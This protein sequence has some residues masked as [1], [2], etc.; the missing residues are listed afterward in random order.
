V[1]LCVIS[2]LATA[3]A[4]RGRA[5]SAPPRISTEKGAKKPPTIQRQPNG[6]PQKMEAAPSIY[7]STASST[8]SLPAKSKNPNRRAV[9]LSAAAEPTAHSGSSAMPKKTKAA[10]N[11]QY[12]EVPH[13][14]RTGEKSPLLHQ[15]PNGKIVDE[16]GKTANIEA[17]AAKKAAR[18]KR[19]SSRLPPNK[20]EGE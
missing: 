14:L 5:K 20:K 2:S 9:N 16:A 15:D 6:L 3:H 8:P 12:D 10:T 13:E 17:L 19:S 18:Q 1:L 11:H 7:V 4:Q